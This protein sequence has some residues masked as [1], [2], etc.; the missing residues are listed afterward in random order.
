MTQVDPNKMTFGEMHEE[1][2]ANDD[3]YVDR[4]E[5]AASMEGENFDDYDTDGDGKISKEE[6]ANGVKKKWATQY[7]ENML[8]GKYFSSKVKE[9]ARTTTEENQYQMFTN[10]IA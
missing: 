1:I 9:N 7:L 3:G 8:T 6:M 5:F 2:D 10:N 4:D